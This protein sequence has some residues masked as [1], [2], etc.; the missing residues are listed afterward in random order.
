MDRM[1][2]AREGFGALL[3]DHCAAHAKT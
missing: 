1:L 2:K 3:R